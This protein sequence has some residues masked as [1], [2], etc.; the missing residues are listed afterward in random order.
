MQNPFIQRRVVSSGEVVVN[1]AGRHLSMVDAEALV[2]RQ[3]QPI[4][5]DEVDSHRQEKN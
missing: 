2:G 5:P 4:D 3:T 1:E